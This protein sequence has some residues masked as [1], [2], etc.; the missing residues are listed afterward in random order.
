MYI[1]YAIINHGKA[2]LLTIQRIFLLVLREQLFFLDG[3]KSKTIL[4]LQKIQIET[5]FIMPSTALPM[6]LN[7]KISICI[8]FDIL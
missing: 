7:L 4:N 8:K 2:I 5:I 6:R 1:N 3:T